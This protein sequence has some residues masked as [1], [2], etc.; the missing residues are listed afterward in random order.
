M[1]NS[2]HLLY[3]LYEEHD[4]KRVRKY[5]EQTSNLSLPRV[6]YTPFLI[7]NTPKK[8]VYLFHFSPTVQATLN[9]DGASAMNGPHSSKIL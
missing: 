9:T 8:S 1:K 3:P 2:F 6:T 7:T 5:A 4:L